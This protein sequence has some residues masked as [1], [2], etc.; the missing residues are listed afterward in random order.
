MI[1]ATSNIFTFGGIPIIH[2]H[3]LQKELIELI[4]EHLGIRAGNALYQFSDMLLSKIYT[5]FIG[6]HFAEDINYVNEG[7]SNMKGYKVSVPILF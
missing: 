6:G 5:C 1:F 7:L 3:I 2:K 4:T